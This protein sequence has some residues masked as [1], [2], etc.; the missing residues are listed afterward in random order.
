MSLIAKLLS[1]L[2]LLGFLASLAAHVAGYAG[3]AQPFG[4]SPQ[5]LGPGIFI[6]WAPTVPAF[7]YLS[8]GCSRK[9]SW[10]AALRGCPVWMSRLLYGVFG[11][12][13]LNFFAFMFSV[14][15]EGTEAAE[16]RLLSGHC[17][18]FY[19]AAFA[20]MYSFAVVV[21]S[22]SQIRR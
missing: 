3:I 14:G 5:P 11:Y 15:G 20:V 21:R 6:V 2:A 16:I 13:F 22:Q 8:S 17:M 18:V 4:I 9:D 1:C 12:G 10:K 19:F 7:M